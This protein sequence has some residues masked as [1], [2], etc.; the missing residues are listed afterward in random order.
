MSFPSFLPTLTTFSPSVIWFIINSKEG[1]NFKILRIN[2]PVSLRQNNS[3]HRS[4]DLVSRSERYVKTHQGT[5]TLKSF[6]EPV[7][8]LDVSKGPISTSECR[9]PCVSLLLRRLLFFVSTIK[10]SFFEDPTEGR[11]KVGVCL[12]TLRSP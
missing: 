2:S 3:L 4:G 7:Q 9:N 1:K 8:D 12:E 5:E 10:K 6:P 11:M